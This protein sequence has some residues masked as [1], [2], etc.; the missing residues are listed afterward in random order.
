[1]QAGK[2]FLSYLHQQDI[3][4]RAFFDCRNNGQM[5][6]NLQRGSLLTSAQMR[7][8]AIGGKK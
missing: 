7:V 1:M 8:L 4:F 5:M 2:H 3:M 6:K